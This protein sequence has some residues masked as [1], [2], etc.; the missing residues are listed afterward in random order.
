MM[1]FSFIYNDK[2]EIP[3]DCEIATS[4]LAMSDKYNIPK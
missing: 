3:S 4:L 1:F 2:V